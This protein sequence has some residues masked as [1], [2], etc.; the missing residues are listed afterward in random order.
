MDKIIA[1]SS[2][3]YRLLFAVLSALAILS[4]IVFT[5]YRVNADSAAPAADEHIITLHDN[6]TDKGFITKKST[7]RAALAEQHIRVDSKD[8]IEPGIDSKLVASSYQ[9]NIYRA[10]P[11]AIH[12]GQI[13]TKVI[14]AYRTASQIAGVAGIALHDEDITKLSPSSNPLADGAAEVMTITRATAFSFSFYGKVE[15]AY[16]QAK[17]VG[18][19]LKEKHI[20]MGP[21][22]GVS[23]SLSTS[24]TAGMS[25]RIW[26]D[27]VQTVTQDEDVAFD[28]KTIQDADQPVGY[29]QVQTPGV[30][31]RRT[32]TYEISMQSGNEVSR[33][34]INSVTTKQ[35][36]QEVVVVG[37]K[38]TLPPGTHEDW[39]AAAG[40]SASDYGY[41]N[42]IVSHEGGWEPCKVQGGSI[43]CTYAADGGAYG[44]GL[45]QATPG[46]KMASAGA[47][48]ATN[49][50]TQLRWATSYAVGRYG[51]WQGAY[52]HWTTH[53]NW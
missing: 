49:P 14:T 47:D 40:I 31:G 39:M 53:H 1:R 8:L 5:S 15:P 38:A 6:G 13:E 12:D 50:I 10:R 21:K 45:V 16:T 41:V 3:R 30:N 2:H 43:D 35:P 33:K 51:S 25:I 29:H 19:M 37:T 44:Y 17:T 46:R 42:Y 23:P 24:I 28:T 22:D 26:R 4:I 20:T 18:D 32:V 27:G 36:T 34:E 11:V 52:Y 7:L 48:W 9:V